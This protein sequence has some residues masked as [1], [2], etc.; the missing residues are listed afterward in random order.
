[1]A[2]RTTDKAVRGI[3]DNDPNISMT[4]FIRMANSLTNRL[5][6]LDAADEAVLDDDTL[7]QI[8]MNLAA[9]FYQSRDREL[10]TKSTGGAGGSFVGQ[11]AKLL[12]GTWHG[13]A[14]LTLDFSGKLAMIGKGRA[15]VTWL[16]TAEDS[17]ERTD[18]D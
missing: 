15:K 10:A 18:L 9:H 12:E 7:E 6:T 17:N 16:G 1:M 5:A 11:T 8:E 14:A 4:P 2:I 13:Q 3:V